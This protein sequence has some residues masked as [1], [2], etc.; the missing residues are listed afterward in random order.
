MP[1]RSLCLTLAFTVVACVALA[2]PAEAG[3][4]SLT[5]E[6]WLPPRRGLF[7][8]PYRENNTFHPSARL[9]YKWNNPHHKH[10]YYSGQGYGYGHGY[11][12]GYG[13]AYG[14]PVAGHA[15]GCQCEYCNGGAHGQGGYGYGHGRLDYAP[16]RYRPDPTVYG[17]YVP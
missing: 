8:D 1:L 13:P 14:G 6:T 10:G 15:V 2:A 4:P 17:V 3:W 16:Y 9:L 5:G 7:G 11:G 12:H